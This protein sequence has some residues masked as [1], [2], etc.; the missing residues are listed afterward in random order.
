MHLLFHIVAAGGIQHFAQGVLN[1]VV[2]H[3]EDEQ[4]DHHAGNGV[5]D[6]KAQLCRPDTQK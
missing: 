4:A 1:D 2:S 5:H 6:G 3:L